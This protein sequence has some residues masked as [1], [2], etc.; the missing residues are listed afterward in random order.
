M[1][2][3]VTVKL[4][5]HAIA[6]LIKKMAKETN[7]EGLYGKVHIEGEDWPYNSC[8]ELMICMPNG[9]EFHT[10]YSISPDLEDL[11]VVYYVQHEEIT[12]G[13]RYYP[14]MSGEPDTSD[15]V[16]DF[17][18]DN[19]YEASKKAILLY[20]ELCINQML[21]VEAE[22]EMIDQMAKDEEEMEK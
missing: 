20:I 12:H 19:P 2:H 14:D 11:K 7:Q 4:A 18:T 21:E 8:V 5:C 15:L 17:I 22:A 16:D 1:N 9:G 10:G 3:P 6:E 13:V